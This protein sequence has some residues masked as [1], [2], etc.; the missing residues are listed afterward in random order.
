M[1]DTGCRTHI[2]GHTLSDRWC[3]TMCPTRWLRNKCATVDCSRGLLSRQRED[4]RPAAAAACLQ[5]QQGLSTG[6]IAAVKPPAAAACLQLQQGF[7]TGNIAAVKQPAAAARSRRPARGTCTAART[8]PTPPASPLQGQ[9]GRTVRVCEGYCTD[10]IT[11]RIARRMQ[12]QSALKLLK[13]QIACSDGDAWCG[14]RACVLPAQTRSGGRV[15][16]ML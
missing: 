9:R 4:D 3:P 8:R 13:L 5:L 1:S 7:S 6:N 10:A 14:G 12:L 16:S 11:E 2:V 15:C